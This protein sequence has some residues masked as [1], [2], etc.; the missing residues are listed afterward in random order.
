MRGHFF[1]L[2][3]EPDVPF[4]WA[5]GAA[6]PGNTLRMQLLEFRLDLFG[7]SILTGTERRDSR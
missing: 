2:A 6:H 5:A 1:V 4:F 7:V 3:I